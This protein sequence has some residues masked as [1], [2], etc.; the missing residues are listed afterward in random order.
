MN[1][2]SSGG[3]EDIDLDDPLGKIYQQ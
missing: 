3:K 1:S 2:G